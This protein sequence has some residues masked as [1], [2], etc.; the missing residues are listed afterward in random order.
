M[1]QVS[2]SGGGHLTY[3]AFVLL[4]LDGEDVAVLPLVERKAR[5]AAPL[6][7]PPAGIA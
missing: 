1:Q 6:Q 4:H 3:F 7:K 5:L 2:D